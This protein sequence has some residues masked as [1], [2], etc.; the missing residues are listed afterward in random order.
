MEYWDI[1][2][3]LACGFYVISIIIGVTYLYRK[4]Q[5]EKKNN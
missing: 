1:K 5:Y 2:T 4:R 3:T